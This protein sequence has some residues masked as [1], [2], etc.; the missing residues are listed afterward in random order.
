MCDCFDTQPQ[1][2]YTV[3]NATF[4]LG[5]GTFW[6]SLSFV[7]IEKLGGTPPTWASH[8]GLVNKPFQSQQQ[9]NGKDFSLDFLVIYPASKGC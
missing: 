5:V 7:I 2:Q 4:S 9:C 1:Q 3:I 8:S 6:D